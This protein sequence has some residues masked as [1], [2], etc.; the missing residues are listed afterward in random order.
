[1]AF[2]ALPSLTIVVA[3]SVTVGGQKQ[4]NRVV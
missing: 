4:L 2:V 3:G 1:V